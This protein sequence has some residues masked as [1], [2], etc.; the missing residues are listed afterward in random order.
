MS[1][2]T[3]RTLNGSLEIIQEISRV[4]SELG[5]PLSMQLYEHIKEEEY[6]VVSDY[7]F[8]YSQPYTSNDFLYARQ[9][10]A[11]VSKQDFLDFGVDRKAVALSKFL[12]TE[13]TCRQTNI[14]FRQAIS[15]DWETNGVLYL[16]SQKISRI[17]GVCPSI[18]DLPLSFG[19]GAN[20]SVKSTQANARVKLSAKL[21]CSSNL[22]PCVQ[23]LL[24]AVP[25][26]SLHHSKYED[27]ESF[28][29]DVALRNGKLAFVPKTSKEERTI[30]I[31]P[32]LNSVLQKGIGTYMKGRLYSAGIDLTDQ[33]RNADLAYRG[34]LY[35]SIATLDL[36]SASDTI[37]REVVWSLLPTP[38]ATLLDMARSESIEHD[39][40]VYLLEKFSSMGNAFTFEL[41][42]LIFYALAWA[43]CKQL[44]I[45]GT[46]ISVYGD[47]IIVP[48]E[49][50]DSL[51]RVLL[52]CG[53]S[54]NMAKSFSEG[55]FRE[56]CGSD[57]LSGLD[58]RP[59]YV[60][61]VI[62][63]RDL[64]V[65][66]NWFI[67]RCEFQLARTVLSF[68]HKPNI[69][70]GPDGYGDGH[71][72]GDFLPRLSR[73]QIRKGYEGSTFDTYLL[74][75]VQYLKQLSGDYLYPTY[76]VYV[77]GG[78]SERPSDMYQVRG[79]RGYKRVSIY[80]LRRNIFSRNF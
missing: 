24:T 43:V 60:R 26:W 76:S 52:D 68:I 10:Q 69:L 49:A 29:C 51:S 48:R 3:K 27:D 28:I 57:Y 12:A 35:G 66:H 30:V 59:F 34:S 1:Y 65:M 70:Y 4:C 58:I 23:E 61:H 40:T 33:S 45:D 22:I 79:T 53:F 39:G 74:K 17:L 2:I 11:L 62:A 16:A 36:S 67:R 63:D 8:D 25:G 20:T 75:P 42:S 32:L 21:E 64:F 14:R 44:D 9:I 55:P 7:N 13:E 37:S 5:G 6:K 72:I 80:T 78:A 50:Y 73:A 31:E 56:S 46:D 18:D 47:D 77:S 71:L 38:W 41:E 19:P 15:L 54:V